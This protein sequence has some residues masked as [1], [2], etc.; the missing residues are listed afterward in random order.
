MCF[1]LRVVVE[2]RE[3]HADA[4][5]DGRPKLRL[6][7]HPVVLEPALHR[8]ELRYPVAIVGVRRKVLDL[9]RDGGAEHLDEIGRPVRP[10]AIAGCLVVPGP[11]AQGR[12]R[13]GTSSLSTTTRRFFAAKRCSPFRDL[14]P[15]L[16][17]IDD[18]LVHLKERHVVVERLVQQDHELD[19]V[20]ARLLPERL[21][22]P[23][24]EIGHERGNAVGQRVG[25]EVVVQRVVAVRRREADLD[26]IVGTAAT[27]EHL[28]DVRTE[29]A[30]HFQDQAAELRR[31]IVR[32]VAKQLLDVRIHARRRLARADG[33]DNDHARV[34]PALRDRQPRRRARALR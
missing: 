2:Q 34:E 20:R 16:V 33:A 5:D 17:R 10:H 26:V 1:T 7:P 13:T 12:S 28:A 24:K 21:L 15:E 23:A 29:V 3:E 32:A 6:D 25:V 27:R 18:V 19:Q 14:E 30:L 4:F 9:V 22:A 8:L 31:R 11:G